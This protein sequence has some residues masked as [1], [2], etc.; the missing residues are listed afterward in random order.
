LP[1]PPRNLDALLKIMFQASSP[2]VFRQLH[3]E[4]ICEW[5]NVD[6]PRVENR[7]VDLLGRTAGGRL[8]HIEFQ[9]ANDPDIPLRMAEYGL[10]ILRKYREYPAQ[11]VIYIGN[12]PLRMNCELRTE[13]LSCQY[14]LVDIRDLESTRLLASVCIEDNLLAVLAAKEDPSAAVHEVASLIRVRGLG[15]N[16]STIS[17]FLLTCELR[18]LLAAAEKELETMPVTMDFD[19]TRYK[20]IGDAARRSKEQGRE[21]GLE[22][23]REQGLE[24]GRRDVCTKQ[25]KKRFGRLP[26]AVTKRIAAMSIAEIDQLALQILDAHS[27]KELFPNPKSPRT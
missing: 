17:Q 26:A 21:E 20:F 4:P 2:E 14:H 24:Q 13:G 19:L 25:L 6:L 3:I 27:L 1:E 7:R 16:D 23:G 9:S 12:P 22:E 5:L 15:N 11:L 10:A 18:G 8:T